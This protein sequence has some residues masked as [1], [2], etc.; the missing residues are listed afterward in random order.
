MMRRPGFWIIV[1]IVFGG[2]ALGLAALGGNINLTEQN[3]V[4]RNAFQPGAATHET[5]ADSQAAL[6]F[7]SATEIESQIQAVSSA[8][9]TR[10]SF[11]ASWDNVTGPTGYLLDVSTSDSF[12]DY[13]EGYHDL[14]VGNVT[15]RVV[16]GLNPGTTYYY[17]VRPYTTTGPGS[18]SEA[19]TATTVS[20]IGLII[21][22]TFDSSITGNPNAAAIE[23]MIN[24][25]ISIYESLFNDPITIQIRFR[26]ATTAPDG[27][28]LSA[29]TISQSDL[30]VYTIPW[31]TFI[32][33]L[34]ADARTSNDNLA[35]TSLPG[36]A[37]SPNIKPSSANG[38]AV[39]LNTPPAMFA[40]GT[41]GNGGPYDGIVT[42]NSAVPYQFTRPVIASNLDAQRSTEHEMD[43]VIGFGSHARLSNLRPQDLFSWSSAGVRNISS[44][45]ARYFSINGGGTN[46]VNFSQDPSG[47]FGDWLS[48]ACPQAH[49]Y[50]QN[51]F[52]C[53]GQSSDIAATSP[54]GI[55]LDVI[56]Y[57]LEGTPIAVP[58]DF[59]N[60]AHSDYLLYNSSTRQTTIWYLNNNI[61]LSSASG[62]TLPGGWQVVAV[63]DF[64]RDGHP[65]CLLF[66]S[67]SRAT[68]IWYMN[69]NVHIGTTSGP[70]LPAGWSVVA[71][72]DF[73]LDGYPDYL[74][75]NANTGG[76][77]VWYM[78][79][80]VHIGSASGPTVPAGWT[81]AGVADFN[82]DNRPDYLLFNAGTHGTVIWY[83]SGVTHIG[84]HVGPTITQGYDVV[85]L[86]DF[87]HNGR[88]DYVLYNSS[89]HQTA[90]WY[91]NNYQ[92]VHTASGPTLPVGW[93]VVA[94]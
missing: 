37:L 66:S 92:L 19:M 73:N 26:Y 38:R 58:Y 47:D 83:M 44:S 11:M 72:A 55:N 45:G 53:T 71:L 43:E 16:T 61:F 28:P 74:L 9:P 69:N 25:A 13:V 84:S 49:S 87:D 85:G 31:I 89:T 20:T 54:E 39:A 48:T 90:I 77:V 75:H 4:S 7:P 65:D 29:G 86:A 3:V 8:P 68:V 41:V 34:R 46:L 88:P 30:V 2:V 82:G 42:L 64:N 57:D 5:R 23:A 63:A 67:T 62:P 51:A 6:Q 78:R 60:D 80:N 79:N 10:S 15:G 12:S 21:H 93:T 94:P 56:G 33:A 18:Y 27:T 22:A 91:L 1:S 35:N 70:A 59:N 50:V 81:V 17:R 36:T 14:D 24:R 76:T 32:N 52:A 40:N